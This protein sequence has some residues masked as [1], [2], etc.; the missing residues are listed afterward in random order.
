MSQTCRK[1]YD[2]IRLFNSA[3]L[4]DR[5]TDGRSNDQAEGKIEKKEDD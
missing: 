5:S 3:M 1:N 2:S 4:A